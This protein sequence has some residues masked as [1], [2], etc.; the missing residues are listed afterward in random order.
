MSGKTES[1]GKMHPTPH[2]TPS[3]RQ[4]WDIINGVLEVTLEPNKP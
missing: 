1:K 4:G 2:Q 3:K